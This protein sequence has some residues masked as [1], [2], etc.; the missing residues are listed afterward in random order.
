MHEL[1]KNETYWKDILDKWDKPLL[2]AF[3][4]NERTTYRLKQVFIDRV[5][6]PTV[7]EDIKNAGHFI[8]EEAGEELAYLINDFIDGKL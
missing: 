5:P 4:E 8:Q 1:A 7:V 2:V 3:G 6:N